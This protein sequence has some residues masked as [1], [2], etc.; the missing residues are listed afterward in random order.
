MPETAERK[1]PGRRP[2]ENPRSAYLNIRLTQ[3][4]LDNIRAHAAA[5]DKDYS[6]LVRERL[7]PLLR[8]L[9]NRRTAPQAKAAPDSDTVDLAAWLG[10]RLNLPAAIVARYV[11]S[12]RIQVAG[13][14]CRSEAVTA[15]AIEAGV[16]FDGRPV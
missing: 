9:G 5:K 3:G 2:S 10:R 6:V 14:E 11:E 4:E 8:P 7:G 15:Q 1:R 13:E 12:G 16:C